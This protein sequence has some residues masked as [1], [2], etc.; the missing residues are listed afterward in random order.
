MRVLVAR[1]CH[2]CPEMCA[3]SHTGYYI[4]Y[5]LS[6]AEGRLAV[7]DSDNTVVRLLTVRIFSEDPP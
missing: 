1:I 3:K 4:E 2:L 7:A 5:G 6:H